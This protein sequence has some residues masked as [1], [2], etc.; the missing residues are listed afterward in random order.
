MTDPKPTSDECDPL[1]ALLVDA[2]VEDEKNR[3]HAAT[4]K[5]IEL[6]YEA[7]RLPY[8]GEAIEADVQRILGGLEQP[9]TTPKPNLAKLRQMGSTT[10][11]LAAV[12]ELYDQQPAP[13]AALEALQKLIRIKQAADGGTELV[14]NQGQALDGYSELYNYRG[15]IEQ[16]EA[17]L[18]AAPAKPKWVGIPVSGL[19]AAL[20]REEQATAPATTEPECPTCGHREVAHS[21]YRCHFGAGESKSEQ[22]Y[23]E[24]YEP[25]CRSCG[26][27]QELHQGGCTLE[28]C[29][30]KA[31]QPAE[32]GGE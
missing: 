23:C 3:R 7:H 21:E 15:V 14:S 2:D 25:A 28:Y 8:D 4:W 13:P 11:Y 24:R 12:G 29:A 22:C 19:A 1:E 5:A 9:P 6:M 18:T 30:C 17:T 20:Q 32:S 31:F 16:Y 10:G 26:H 27:T